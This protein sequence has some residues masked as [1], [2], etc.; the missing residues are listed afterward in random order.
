MKPDEFTT[1]LTTAFKHLADYSTDG[2]IHYHCMDWRHMSEIL[3]SGKAVYSSLINLCVWDKLGAGLGSL[4]R[5]SHELVFVFKNGTASHINNVELGVHG[6]YRTNCWRYRGM[7]AS[8]PEAKNLLNYHPTIKPV[9]M[10]MDALLDCSNPNDVVLD[11]FAGSGSTLLAAERTKRRARIIEIDEH[12]GNVIL[13]RWEKLT[14]K[15]AQL[16][17]NYE[18]ANNE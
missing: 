13:H 18:V 12:Y 16:L 8:N 4:Y 7:H 3:E 1:F 11:C 5:S 15:K 6:R 14:G 2:S 9:A 17:S 10:I